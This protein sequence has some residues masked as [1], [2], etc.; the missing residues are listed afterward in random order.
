[1]ETLYKKSQIGNNTSKGY[2][3]FYKVFLLILFGVST[4]VILIESDQAVFIY[5]EPYKCTYPLTL[6][7]IHSI[8]SLLGIHPNAKFKRGKIKNWKQEDV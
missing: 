7:S 5:Q 2:E 3:S 1:M 4:D 6:Y 8:I